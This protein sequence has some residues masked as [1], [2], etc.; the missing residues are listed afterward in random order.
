MVKVIKYGQK[1]RV[2]CEVCGALLEFEKD[3]VKTVQMGMNE[4]E[5]QIE[6]P[7]CNETVEI[8]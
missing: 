1:R 2:T 5:Q 7:A 3:D 4:Y 8:N 6:C